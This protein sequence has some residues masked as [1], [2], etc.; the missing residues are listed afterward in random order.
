[1]AKV[2]FAE[3]LKL[4]VNIEEVI[5][6]EEF[7][8]KGFHTWPLIRQILW[9][10]LISSPDNR[11]I[12]E[13]GDKIPFFLHIKNIASY[14]LDTF[15]RTKIKKNSKVIFFSRTAYLQ[16]MHSERFFDRIVDPI[17]ESFG[18][19]EQVTK[20]Y[21]TEIP[22]EKELIH[23]FF[24]L[25]QNR[26]LMTIKIPIQQKKLLNDIAKIL[27]IDNLE[28]QQ[29]FSRELRKFVGWY[30]SAKKLLKKHLNLEEIYIGCWYFPDM[31]GVCAAADELG[32]KTIDVQHGKQGKYQAMYSGWTKIPKNGYA[33]MPDKFWCWGQ[34]SCDHILASSPKRCNHIPFIGGHP[35]IEYYITN[36]TSQ[37]Y[38]LPK[39][40]YRVLLTLQRNVT[41]RIPNFVLEY[42][43]SNKKYNAYFIFRIHPND[44]DGYE[45]CKQRLKG[46]HESLYTIDHGEKNLYDIFKVITHHMTAYS[47]CSY[48]ACVFGVP[49]LL[50]GF[51]SKEIY[52]DD[53]RKKVFKWIDSNKND[54][55]N[56]L[57]SD[58]QVRITQNSYIDN[59]SIDR[60]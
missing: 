5:N 58:K 15:R 35:W 13:K 33:L 11:K 30:T 45:Y 28:L 53:I 49:T 34:P 3:A 4:I 8:W 44:K 37:D 7:L 14:L 52:A 27:D 36:I 59:S 29:S 46:I 26:P 10:K 6:T 9:F 47:S 12:F 20:Y 25:Y 55:I 40:K 32:I 22:K 54:F 1:M 56:A 19:N 48:E 43:L 41:E 18:T 39:K 42:L 60:V 21:S 57:E 17:I 50:Y 31:M 2:K 23:S 38:Q 16:K 51:E 24:Y